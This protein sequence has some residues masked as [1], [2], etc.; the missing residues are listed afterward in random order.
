MLSFTCAFYVVWTYMS[1]KIEE[2]K[3]RGA[4][5]K[6]KGKGARYFIESYNDLVFNNFKIIL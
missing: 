2:E 1:K 3:G 4:L 6:T 5:I